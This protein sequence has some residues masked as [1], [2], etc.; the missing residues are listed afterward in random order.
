MSRAES[1]ELLWHH[2][3]WHRIMHEPYI[4]QRLGM[5]CFREIKNYDIQ[6]PRIGDCMWYNGLVVVAIMC[7]ASRYH[8]VSRS[9]GAL[10]VVPCCPTDSFRWLYM[11]TEEIFYYSRGDIIKVRRGRA[12]RHLVSRTSAAPSP[13]SPMSVS[14]SVRPS[15]SCISILYSAFCWGVEFSLFLYN[16]VE[17]FQEFIQV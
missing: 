4:S 16:C 13:P 6:R 12:S 2:H 7:T 8:V 9:V 14:Q 3:G 5:A 15:A 10:V 17:T 1:I 11:G